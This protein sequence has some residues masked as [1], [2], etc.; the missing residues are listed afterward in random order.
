MNRLIDIAMPPGFN[1][2]MGIDP[3][4]ITVNFKTGVVRYVTVAR[5]TSAI[6]AMYEGIRCSTG[7][8]RVYARQVKG[9]P[10][11]PTTDSTWRNMND[12]SGVMFRHPAVLAQSGVCDG[13]TITRNALQ[14]GQ[15]LGSNLV[16]GHRR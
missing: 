2:K 13:P 5:G 14:I 11:Q 8:F 3:N 12:P 16:D 7:E 15:A 4:T 6:N 9:Q 1:V 10:W